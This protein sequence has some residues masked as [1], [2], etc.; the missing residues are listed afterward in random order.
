MQLPGGGQDQSSYLI[1]DINA[2][3]AALFI[4]KNMLF[5]K[6]HHLWESPN[7]ITEMTETVGVL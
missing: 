1:Q 2:E 5:H 4:L 3:T 6:M 7:Y